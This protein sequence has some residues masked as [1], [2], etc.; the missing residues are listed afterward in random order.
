VPVIGF[1]VGGSMLLS[2]DVTTT[3]SRIN[4]KFG[5]ATGFE[6]A[7][8]IVSLVL[9]GLGYLLVL[10][11]MIHGALESLAG[12]PVSIGGCLAAGLSALPRTFIAALLAIITALICGA[13][14]MFVFSAI[15]SIILVGI[16]ASIGLSLLI[17]MICARLMLFIP[18]IMVE[19]AGVLEC[20]GRSQDLT[21]EH[22]WGLF[23]IVLLISVVNWIVPFASAALAAVSPEAS[24]VFNIAFGVFFIAFIAV[25]TGV[26]YHVLRTGKEGA[27]VG[28]IAKVFD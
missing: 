6:G 9:G 5:A 23:G 3:G 15:F 25:L 26:A 8:I 27:P 21:R 14:A 16:V 17:L 13:M 22:R 1:M 10:S 20:F 19:R 24:N 28:E 18:A 11:A 12:R 4:F 2:G 7:F